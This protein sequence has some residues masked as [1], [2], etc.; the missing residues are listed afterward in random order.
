MNITVCL[1]KSKFLHLT[2][3]SFGIPPFYFPILLFLP[4][5][6]QLEYAGESPKNQGFTS[7]L[8]TYG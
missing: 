1:L 2:I 8:A 7:H 6:S 3:S 5:L 4:R